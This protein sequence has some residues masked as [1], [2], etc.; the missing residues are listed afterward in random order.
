MQIIKPVAGTEVTRGV[1][2]CCLSCFFIVAMVGVVFIVFIVFFLLMWRM[3]AATP[4]RGPT[5]F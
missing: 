3:G 4:R 1:V 5:V 2:H